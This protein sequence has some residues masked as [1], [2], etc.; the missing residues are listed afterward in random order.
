[1]EFEAFKDDLEH[2]KTTACAKKHGISKASIAKFR[3]KYNITPKYSGK[4][5][6]DKELILRQEEYLRQQKLEKG[7]R[8]RTKAVPKTAEKLDSVPKVTETAEK[9]DSD[10]KVTKTAEKLDSVPKVTKTVEKLSSVPK[11]TKLDLLKKKREKD[12]K[13]VINSDL[14][15]QERIHMRNSIDA[16]YKKDIKNL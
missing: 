5:G 3:K 12:L 16:K 1:M 14:N 4:I 2:L 10:P 9:L 8:V 6:Y 11:V 7:K 13:T 15:S